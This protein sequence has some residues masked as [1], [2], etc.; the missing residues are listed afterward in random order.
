[1]LGD[2]KSDSFSTSENETFLRMWFTPGSDSHSLIPRATSGH[3]TFCL[4]VKSTGLSLKLVPLE[5]HMKNNPF[6]SQPP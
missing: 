2:E 5:S 3:V 4:C 1:M 6:V